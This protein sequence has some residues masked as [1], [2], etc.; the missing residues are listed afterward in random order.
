MCVP[1]MK[2]SFNTTASSDQTH[3]NEASFLNFNE[4]HISKRK[5]MVTISVLM[6]MK[7]DNKCCLPD[8]L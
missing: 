1:V 3:D 4:S 7:S 5:M 8:P 6:M 2:M